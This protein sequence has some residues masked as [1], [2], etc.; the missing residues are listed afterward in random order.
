MKTYIISILG[1]AVLGIIIDIIMPNG[2]IN[3][4]IKSIYSIFIV[5]VIIGPLINLISRKDNIDLIYKD[6]LVDEK[7][8]NYINEYK[9]N[10]IENNIK[11]Q[12]KEEGF[13]GIDILIEYSTENN[14]LILNFC[15]V[16]LTNLEISADKQHINNYEFI[17][18][19]VKKYT[20]LIDEE[21]IIYE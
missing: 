16:N 4:Y 10:S 19:I 5:A 8:I 6:Y 15:K 1:V 3:K 13:D 7:I 21:I 17:T 12:L 20:G 9:V 14:E 2:S 18:E 11:Y